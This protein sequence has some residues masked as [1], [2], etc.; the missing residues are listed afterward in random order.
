MR[1]FRHLTDGPHGNEQS[2]GDNDI[3]IA[4]SVES[5]PFLG[6]PALGIYKNGVEFAQCMCVLHGGVA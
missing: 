4:R 6:D 3:F 1:R 5:K 2:T